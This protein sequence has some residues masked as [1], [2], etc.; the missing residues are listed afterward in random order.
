MSA[1][2]MHRLLMVCNYID[3]MKEV[4]EFDLRRHFSLSQSLYAQLKSDLIHANTFKW[5]VEFNK[6]TKV[7]RYI[8]GEAEAEARKKKD[9]RRKDDAENS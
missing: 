1:K 5:R 8:G 9:E 6:E 7:W 4:G 3:K 2:E